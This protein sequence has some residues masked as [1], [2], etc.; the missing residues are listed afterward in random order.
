MNQIFMVIYKFGQ[1]KRTSLVRKRKHNIFLATPCYGGLITDQYFLS[2]FRLT[3][4][5]I[6]YNV[7]FRIT[8]PLS[9]G[10]QS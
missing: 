7:N 2:I 5:L 3:Q 1:K 6:K 8:S 4:E 10:R 9:T